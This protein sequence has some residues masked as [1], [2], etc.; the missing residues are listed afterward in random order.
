[1]SHPIYVCIYSILFHFLRAFL[2]YYNQ[3]KLFKNEF[4]CRK[5]LR[6]YAVFYYKLVNIIVGNLFLEDC[7]LKDTSS[8]NKPK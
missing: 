4:Q 5:H 1:M 2:A 3:S 7:D 6:K 8:A